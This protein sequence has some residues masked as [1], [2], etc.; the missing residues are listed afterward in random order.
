ML[1]SGDHLLSVDD[2]YGGTGRYFRQCATRFGIEVDFVDATNVA[3]F[4]KS[5]K[6]NTK[7][8]KLEISRL[9]KLI[10]HFMCVDGVGG[11]SY[12]PPAEGHGHQGHR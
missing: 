9:L 7:V 1:S 6:P 10:T 2:V 8:I 5:I 12:Q 11:V 4:E 3:L